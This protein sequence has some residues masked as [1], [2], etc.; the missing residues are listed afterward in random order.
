MLRRLTIWKGRSTW[1]RVSNRST[2]SEVGGPAGAGAMGDSGDGSGGGLAASAGASRA[3]SGISSRD[4][5][6]RQ[7]EAQKA[8]E[9]AAAHAAAQVLGADLVWYRQKTGD[10]LLDRHVVDVPLG[11]AGSCDGALMV[12]YCGLTAS[13]PAS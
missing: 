2:T 3:S 13:V 4:E 12:G 6:Q 7:R 8:A 1:R 10:P 9:A 5:R 11:K